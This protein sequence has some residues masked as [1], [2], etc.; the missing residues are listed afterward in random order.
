MDNFV[1][2]LIME[3]TGLA[4]FQGDIAQYFLR[5]FNDLRIFLHMGDIDQ[6]PFSAEDVKRYIEAHRKDTWIIVAKEKNN[7]IPIGYSGLFIR[8]RHR[9]GIIR[10]AIGEKEYLRKGYA[11]RAKILTLSWA[12]NECDLVS[13]IS[14]VSSSNKANSEL[15]L[16]VGFKECGRYKDARFEDGKRYDEI[17]LQITRREF[18]EKYPNFSK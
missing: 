12:F 7:W 5:W 2:R 6:F 18:Y 11:T 8:S 13:V 10:N 3:N 14:S 15:C 4:S 9:V 1:P 16:K 17:H